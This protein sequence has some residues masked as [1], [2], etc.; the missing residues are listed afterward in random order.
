MTRKL[1]LL[2]CDGTIRRPKTYAH[3]SGAQVHHEFI[4]SPTDQELIPGAA[5][6]IA[7]CTVTGNWSVVGISNQGGVAAGK[8]SLSDA[9]EE[10]RYTLELCPLLMAILFCPDWDGEICYRTR[11]PFGTQRV[12]HFV[13]QYR[14]P[15]PGMLLEAAYLYKADTL[16]YVGDRPEDQQAA[17]NAGIDFLWADAWRMVD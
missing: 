14:K 5:E 3:G 6:A 7:R 8:K 11:L 1:L 9:C 15:G 2:D 4:E 13:G 17:M 10:Q 12:H 16:L